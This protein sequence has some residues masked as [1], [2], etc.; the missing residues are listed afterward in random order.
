MSPA[1]PLFIPMNCNYLV[2][3][4]GFSTALYSTEVTMPMFGLAD[5]NSFYA[6]CEALFAQICEANRLLFLV[7]TTDV[8]SHAMLVQ[9]R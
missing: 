5:V 9:K 3:L 8:L 4:R 1:F 6:S 2:L 7:T